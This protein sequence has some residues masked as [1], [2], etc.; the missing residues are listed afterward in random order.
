MATWVLGSPTWTMVLSR[1]VVM[2]EIVD[3]IDARRVGMTM[4]KVSLFRAR[5]AANDPS[6][7]I[8][9]FQR[10]RAP[11]L[12]IGNV[13]CALVPTVTCARAAANLT[14]YMK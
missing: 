14:H 11:T 12:A 3:A 10:S 1:Y 2:I 7:K 6:T 8:V 9:L 13:V 4:R 5:H